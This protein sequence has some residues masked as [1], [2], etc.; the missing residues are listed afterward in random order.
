[1]CIYIVVQPSSPSIS[2]KF[3]RKYS[4]KVLICVNFLCT[5]KWLSYTHICSFFLLFRAAGVAYGSSQARELM[6]VIG[7][8]PAS[9]HHSHCNTR[10]L[11]HQARP[12]IE[13]TSSWI[14]VR[15]ISTEP[16]W[17][18]PHIIYSFPLWFIIGYWIHFPLLYSRTL[19]S[20]N[21]SS[22][23]LK[24]CYPSNTDF[25]LPPPS[26]PGNHY[27]TFC[28]HEFNGSTCLIEYNV[29]L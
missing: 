1:M 27:L 19:L 14:L 6:H 2:E 23:K 10:S 20:I 7:A 15:F 24:L 13:P 18:L 28:L 29:L 12:G 3:Q 22:Q 8:T 16:Q 26:S 4:K 21:F 5:A 11:I 9:L 25:Q 17:E